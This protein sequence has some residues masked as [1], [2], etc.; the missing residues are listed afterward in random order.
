MDGARLHAEP[1]RATAQPRP[2]ADHRRRR[3]V[4]HPAAGGRAAARR[5]RRP[6]RQRVRPRHLQR[7]VG[8]EARPLP[9]HARPVAAHRRAARDVAP[10][11]RRGRVPVLDRA[12][13]PVV[14]IDVHTP[15]VAAHA[16]GRSATTSAGGALAARHLLDLGHRDIGFIGDAVEDP[17]GFTS[18][19]DR[20]RGLTRRAGDAPAS[21]SRPSGSATAPTA[22]TRRGTSRVGC[23]PAT[24]RPTA[25]FAASDTQALGRHRRGARARPPRAGRPVGRSATT[26]SRPPTTSA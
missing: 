24:D 5:R 21:R 10:A 23:S 13:V 20:E 11:A 9:G 15:S 7:R 18:S 6:D 12:P 19:R 22:A 25:I 26:T 4:P 8:P 16:A 3:L 17:F 2:D 14:F 1:G